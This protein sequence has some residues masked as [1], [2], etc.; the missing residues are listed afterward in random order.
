SSTTVLEYVASLRLESFFVCNYYLSLNSNFTSTLGTVIYSSMTLGVID[1][2]YFQY[3]TRSGVVVIRDA[4]LYDGHTRLAQSCPNIRDSITTRSI[5]TKIFSLFLRIARENLETGVTTIIAVNN[6]LRFKIIANSLSNS[7]FRSDLSIKRGTLTPTSDTSAKP[8]TQCCRLF[9]AF[10]REEREDSCTFSS[11]SLNYN[12]FHLSKIKFA[13]NDSL[14]SRRMFACD[15]TPIQ[16]R[17]LTV[18]TRQS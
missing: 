15:Y 16:Y 13:S 1:K 4:C 5:L 10:L 7:P 11:K 3:L 6:V 14:V 2:S 8:S 9:V 18:Y 12:L 17:Y